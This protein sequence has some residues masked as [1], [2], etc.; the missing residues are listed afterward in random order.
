VWLAAVAC[1]GF[2]REGDLRQR[3][4]QLLDQGMRELHGQRRLLHD[5]LA[6]Q[7]VEHRAVAAQR[8]AAQAEVRRDRAHAPRRARRDDH[9]REPRSLRRTQRRRGA[10]RQAAVAPEQGA[11]KIERN[12]LPLG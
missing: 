1:A 10:R 12:E 7:V 3:A 2:D 9:E 8:E 11:I 4:P 5:A 6:I